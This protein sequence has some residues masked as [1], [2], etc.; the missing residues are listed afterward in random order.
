VKQAAGETAQG[1]FE[2]ARDAAMSAA[3]SAANSVSNADL[4]GHASRM[5]KN[6]ADTLK[7]V[8]DDVVTTAFNPSRTPN[9]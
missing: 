7:E 4:G 1:G 9:T 3:D 8:A 6:M 5:T 2:A